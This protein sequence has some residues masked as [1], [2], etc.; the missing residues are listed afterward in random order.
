MSDKCPTRPSKQKELHMTEPVDRIETWVLNNL[1]C[2]PKTQR[3]LSRHVANRDRRH[4]KQALH[5][6]EQDGLIT[7][8]HKTGCVGWYGNT[9]T[10][11]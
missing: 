8:H 2:G 11:S 4:L 5:Q 9:W 1:R 6:L 3:E 7:R 10:R